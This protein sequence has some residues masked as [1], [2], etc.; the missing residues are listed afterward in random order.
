MPK[1]LF[2][3]PYSDTRTIEFP[4]VDGEP[5]Q[6]IYDTGEMVETLHADATYEAR[7]VLNEDGNPTGE[8]TQVFVGYG[9]PYPATV[10]LMR[11]GWQMR[12]DIAAPNPNTAAVEIETSEDSMDILIAHED[13]VW[14]EDVDE[15]EE[16]I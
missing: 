9:E 6:M 15:P 1:A 16:L 14:L 2:L 10:P 7:D 13:W 4:L 12:S 5:L 3:T 8:T 11:G